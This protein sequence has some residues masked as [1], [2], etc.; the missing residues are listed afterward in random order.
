MQ[1]VLTIVGRRKMFEHTCVFCRLAA[2]DNTTDGLLNELM[3]EVERSSAAAMRSIQSTVQS[4]LTSRPLVE[5]SNA[6]QRGGS[7]LE[8][9][10]SGYAGSL[11]DGAAGLTRS[12]RAYDDARHTVFQC[13]SAFCIVHALFVST[14]ALWY[15]KKSKARYPSAT[16]S[17]ITWFC[18]FCSITF[19]LLFTGILALLF[20]PVSELCAFWR[21]DL[22]TYDGIADYHRQLGFVKPS[23]TG[24]RMDPI[25][26]DVARTCLTP[27]ATGDLLGALQLR[28]R[29]NFQQV[30]DDKFVEL[31]AKMAGKVVD[32][33]K[34]ELLVLRAQSYG[35]L[36][37]LDPDSPLPLEPNAAPKM[38][39]SSLDPDDQ[40]APDGEDIIYG[41]NTY[42]RLIAGQGKFSFSSGTMGGGVRITATRPTEA[43]MAQEP[44]Q[45]RHALIYA[46]LKEQILSEQSIFRC[47]VL[48]ADFSVE[49]RPC[50]FLEFRS[51]VVSWAQQVREAGHHL[52]N[53]ARV[54]Q[55]LIADNMRESLLDVLLESREL[56][57]LF[58]CRFLWRRWEEFD[59]ALC[60]EA[61]PG[62]L[63]GGVVWIVAGLF[64]LIL[65][66]VH[67]KMW[68]HFLDNKVVGS[69]L[70]RFSKKYGYLSAKGGAGKQQQGITNA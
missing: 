32:T 25:A 62:M 49:E 46:R 39:G 13:A 2:G 37:I 42:A 21:Y 55:K 4:T 10:K 60:N 17:W 65:L 12:V 14:A 61:L 11:I 41:L 22:M 67:Y 69:E 23:A 64:S 44:L 31:Q 70:E 38:L 33:A 26:V 15:T 51:S 35:G 47:D 1:R 3:I 45:T 43:E 40:D 19:A 24:G 63:E 57:Q 27:N 18:A 34:F 7:A 9:F 66:V 59:F 36:F 54:A 28:E 50:G 48:R 6:V 53:E 58:R 52:G 16:P 68:R 5:V 30:L 20:V 29:L 8:V 56:R